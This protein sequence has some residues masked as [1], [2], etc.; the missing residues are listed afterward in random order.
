MSKERKPYT[1]S[2]CNV[3]WESASKRIPRHR[4]KGEFKGKVGT[5]IPAKGHPDYEEP[6]VETGPIVGD[7]VFDTPEFDEESIAP[8]SKAEEYEE[9]EVFV[10][11]E[12]EEKKE[13]EPVASPAKGEAPSSK[14]ITPALMQTIEALTSNKPLT[15]ET[16]TLLSAQLVD[17]AVELETTPVRAEI[18]GTPLLIGIA[19]L[20]AAL[21]LRTT[22]SS[23][24]KKVKGK[25][26]DP[27]EEW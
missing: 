12:P 6:V 10:L 3:E 26:P 16:A 23:V 8:I 11:R 2:V 19:L 24:K 13:K 27:E 25:E 9:E 21:Y 20:T 5:G 7:V 1:C 17:S 14:S 22:M 15:K 4:C 18:T